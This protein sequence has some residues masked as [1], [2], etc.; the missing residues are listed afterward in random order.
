MAEVEEES[1]EGA[2]PKRSIWEGSI[3]IGLVN[4][5]VKLHGMIFDKSIKFRFLHNKDGQPLKYQKVCVKDNTVVPWSDTA[6]GFEVSKGE[7]VIFD[8]SELAAI[9]VESDRRIRIIKFVDYLSVDPV[10]FERSYILMPDKSGEA[11]RLLMTT[12]ERMG[13][14]GVG[15]ITLRTKEYPA[16][17]HVYKGALIL[18]TLRYAYEVAD[19]E[20]IA[21]LRELK[22]PTKEEVDLAMVIV[23]D[24]SGEFDIQDFKDSYKDKL[25]ELLKKKMKG[26]RIMAER[27]VKEEA[28]ELMAA[29]EETLSQLKKK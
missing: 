25:E 24:L 27:P 14:A 20:S 10:Y 8:K 19:P 13:K 17:I 16:L 15:R 1:V 7:F 11:Y 22:E 2:S 21:S 26:E 18:T 29:L 3:S 28:K 23:K 5:P 9:R 4:I 6:K 12:L